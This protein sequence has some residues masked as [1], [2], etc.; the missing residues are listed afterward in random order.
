[1]EGTGHLLWRFP[2]T[3][4]W[5]WV[6]SLQRKT[7]GHMETSSW[8][9]DKSYRQMMQTLSHERFFQITGVKDS[10]ST[11]TQMKQLSDKQRKTTQRGWN[12]WFS[13]SRWPFLHPHCH[14]GVFRSHQQNNNPRPDSG[15][16]LLSTDDILPPVDTLRMGIWLNVPTSYGIRKTSVR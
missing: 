9:W 8:T 6:L 15:L 14:G 7:P 1:M 3:H 5:Q 10:M 12:K 4:L 11:A 13:K 2:W 16:H